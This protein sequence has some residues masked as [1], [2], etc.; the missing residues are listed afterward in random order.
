MKTYI[1]Q[2]QARY[3][4][5]NRK[6][7]N[8]TNSTEPTEQQSIVTV[9]P[10]INNYAPYHFVSP[11]NAYPHSV[12]SNAQTTL[13]ACPSP[14]MANSSGFGAHIMS[15]LYSN[16]P[17]SY[18]HEYMKPVNENIVFFNNLNNSVVKLPKSRKVPSATVRTLPT[19]AQQNVRLQATIQP[20]SRAPD[21]RD[22][23]I[24]KLFYTKTRT[25][26]TI[27]TKHGEKVLSIPSDRYNSYVSFQL[28]EDENRYFAFMPNAKYKD[29]E[30][31]AIHGVEERL[32][33]SYQIIINSNQLNTGY[34]SKLNSV[35]IFPAANSLQKLNV[36][37]K[38][39]KNFF[40]KEQ[41]EDIIEF[42]I[43]NFVKKDHSYT[44][45]PRTFKCFKFDN[46]NKNHNTI[47]EKVEEMIS[48]LVNLDDLHQ[49]KIKKRRAPCIT[50]PTHALAAPTLENNPSNESNYEGIDGNYNIS[51]DYS[52]PSDLSLFAQPHSLFSQ[53]AFQ[54]QIS[55]EYNDNVM[56]ENELYI[57]KTP[58]N[59]HVYP[60]THEEGIDDIYNIFVGGSHSCNLEL[61]NQTVSLFSTVASQYQSPLELNE[62]VSNEGG[63]LTAEAISLY[64][65]T[66][67]DLASC[68]SEH[69]VNDQNIDDDYN[70]KP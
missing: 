14:N 58:E 69:D 48:H 62:D 47:I 60:T 5:A 66:I 15:H 20:D 33:Q 37:I 38:M 2:L 45:K 35:L 16:T 51:T 53:T 57:S 1:K 12:N 17:V 3:Y 21:R 68:V 65:S 41:D 8:S 30:N 32:C 67:N 18:T 63:L 22:N 43:F 25:E 59:I 31:I 42:D 39:V 56:N 26:C 46:N 44:T 49:E 27:E 11:L 36:P 7:K 6:A 34:I 54:S 10:P 23:R 64:Q 24:K 28:S 55:F 13:S 40:T 70:F 61:S 4:K 19:H 52:V 9:H 50:T 29:R